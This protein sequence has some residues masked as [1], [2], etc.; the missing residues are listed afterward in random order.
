MGLGEI[1]AGKLA[2]NNVDL[3]NVLLVRDDRQASGVRCCWTGLSL[4]KGTDDHGNV[5]LTP[6]ERLGRLMR[7]D[8]YY[9]VR[10]AGLPQQV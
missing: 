2:H 5:R 8:D 1:H 6:E 7:R 10:L 3:S 9:Q 4:A